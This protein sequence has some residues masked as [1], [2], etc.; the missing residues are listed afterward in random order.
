MQLPNLPCLA[1]LLPAPSLSPDLHP[2]LYPLWTVNLLATV[3]VSIL[4]LRNALRCVPQDLEDAARIDGC[5][6]RR[7]CCQVILPVVLP[8]LGFLALFIFITA[9]DDAIAPAIESSAETPASPGLYA[10]H[11]SATGIRAGDGS[12]GLIMAA[13]LLLTPLVVAMI[14]FALRYFRKA[15]ASPAQKT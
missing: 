2:A 5:G 14:L 8:A 7:A 1:G 13:S 4:L 9:C 11:L 6:F 3:V 12:L 15:E 10:L